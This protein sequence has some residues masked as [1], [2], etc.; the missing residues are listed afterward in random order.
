MNENK[1]PMVADYKS[2]TGETYHFEFFESDNFD[3]VP[4]ESITQSA[5]FAFHKDKILIVNNST[6]P[7]QYGPVMGG[8]EKGENPNHTLA[9]EL[10]EESNMRLI[11]YKLIGYQKATVIEKPERP[12]DYHM[13]Y[14]AIVEPFGPFTPDCDPDGDVTEL[15]EVELKDFKKYCNWGEIGDFIMQKSLEW[16][17]ERN[18]GFDN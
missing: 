6:K 18:K 8:V 3:N 15:L 11:D 7:G 12:A 2:M 14:V 9:R 16:V 13:R 1:F 10:K 4:L 17:A 5:V